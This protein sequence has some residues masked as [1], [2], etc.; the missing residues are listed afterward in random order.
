MKGS[1]RRLCCADKKCR[2]EQPRHDLR[3]DLTRGASG[4][5]KQIRERFYGSD[6]K[7]RQ[8]LREMLVE[9]D[10][11][12]IVSTRRT[13]ADVCAGWLEAKR[14]VVEP[15]T[16]ERYEAIA[17]RFIVPALGASLAER[18]R[19]LDVAS[20]AAK[21][22]EQLTPRGVS[23]VLGELRAIFAWGIRMN[24]VA[25]NPAL[26]IDPPR[27]DHKEMKT[28]DEAGVATLLRAAGGTYMQPVLALLIL[29]GMRRGEA[30]G[31]KWSDFDVSEGRLTVRRS[32]ESHN[33]ELRIKAPK[34]TRSARTIA[35]GSEAVDVLRIHRRSQLELRL[36]LGQRA[37]STDDWIF[38]TIEGEPLNPRAFSN[39]FARL[40]DKAGLDVRLHDL[41]HSFA[42]I[43][44]GAGVP[45]QTVSRSLGHSGIAITDTIYVH[46]VEQLERDAAVRINE[47]IGDT[48]REALRPAVGDFSSPSV[49]QRWHKEETT[50][51]KARGSCV[52]MVAGPGFEPGTFG[53]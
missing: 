12:L 52:S 50:S 23:H 14:A 16:F 13:F 34:T 25:T 30:L 26:T 37:A 46:R 2:C 11:G 18:I 7:A 33:G 24:V 20:A 9:A 4:K 15:R 22:R 21:W 3:I 5:R 42:T 45:L 53:L 29:T 48:V 36:A 17:R 32:L 35:L 8:R 49:T 6:A 40:V 51:A 28:L 10:R 19:P 41:R 47:A 31:L 27:V 1:I 38:Q 39:R 44:L 43:A